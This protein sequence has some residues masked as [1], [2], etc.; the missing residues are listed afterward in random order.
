MSPVD[1]LDLPIPAINRLWDCID[2]LEAQK[3]LSEL[4]ASDYPNY[5]AKDR[6]KYHKWVFEK[7]FPQKEKKTVVTQQDLNRVLGLNNG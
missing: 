2:I 3:H 5:K 4:K 7:A 1:V 6:S